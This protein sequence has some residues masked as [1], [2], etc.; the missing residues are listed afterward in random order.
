VALAAAEWYCS[1]KEQQVK[2]L[3]AFTFPNQTA[4]EN[5]VISLPLVKLADVCAF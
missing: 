3:S 5:C 4:A 2:E 1:A